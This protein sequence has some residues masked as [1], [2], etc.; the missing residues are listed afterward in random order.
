MFL[1]YDY[2]VVFDESNI[3]RALTECLTTHVYIVLSYDALLIPANP[4]TTT[5][6]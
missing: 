3:L 5:T 2:L 6:L 4:T 1:R